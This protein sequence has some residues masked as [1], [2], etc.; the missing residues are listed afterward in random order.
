MAKRASLGDFT[1][2]PVA[3]GAD[4][5]KVVASGVAAEAVS[6]S[7]KEYPKITVYLT[8]D[9][10]RTLKLIALDMKGVNVSDLGAKAIREYLERN[11]HSRGKQFTA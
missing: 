11:G 4:S 2:K 7:R 5:G 10:V 6:A 3:A 8:A 9:E 1:P